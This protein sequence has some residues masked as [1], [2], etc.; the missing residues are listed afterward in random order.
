MLEELQ[1]WWQDLGPDAQIALQAGSGALVGI[2]GGQFLATVV[3]RTLRAHNFDAVLRLP[4]ATPAPA[5]AEHGFTP[6]MVAANLARVTFWSL[7][8]WWVARLYG[9]AE[10][11]QRLALIVGRTSGSR[12]IGT[13]AVRL[14]SVAPT[15]RVAAGEVQVK[16]A[17]GPHSGAG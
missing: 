17:R 2:L 15:G 12:P 4:R 13:L 11:A 16:G 6:T 5:E 7:A 3:L 9:Q 8:I 14:G 1:T 10:F